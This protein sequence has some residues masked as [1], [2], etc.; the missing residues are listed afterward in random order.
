VSGRIVRISVS[1]GGVPKTA[2]A[3]ARVTPLGLEGDAHRD[4]ENH[5]AP[6]R[7]VCLYAM[8]AIRGVQAEGHTIVPGAIV[9]NVTIEGVDWPAVV[10]GSHVLLGERVPR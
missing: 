4:T 3:A 6:E 2:V 10:P 9:E 7:A 8:E 5:G 1:C